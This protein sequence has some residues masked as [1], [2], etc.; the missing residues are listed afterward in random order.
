MV[1]SLPIIAFM[2]L[3][4]KVA[5]ALIAQKK[6]LALAESCSGGLFSHRLTNIPGSS[7]FLKWGCIAYSNETKIKLLRVPFS[8][9]Q[10]YGAV[11]AQ[12]AVAMATNIRNILK[13]DLGVGIT[14]IAGPTGATSKKPI[15]L[16]YIAIKTARESLCVQ[17]HF[18]GKRTSIK[19]Q[20]V[21]QTFRLLLE[22]L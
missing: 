8:T 6:T 11:S 3:E 16:T 5:Q 17:C 12:V 9:L 21:R 7:H 18:K 1:L 2:K 4:Q 19:S 13:T 20:A 22:F 10:K 15:G 14:G